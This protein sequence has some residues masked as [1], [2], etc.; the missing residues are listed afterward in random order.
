M[1]KILM[2][3]LVESGIAPE[4]AAGKLASHSLRRGGACAYLAAGCDRYDVMRFGRWKSEAGFDYYV[5]LF[6]DQI[7]RFQETAYNKV[8][9][10]E[11][12]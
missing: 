4:V 3:H 11:I 7:A 10:F 1:N 2:E 12:R 8:C 6:E 5:S 9:E